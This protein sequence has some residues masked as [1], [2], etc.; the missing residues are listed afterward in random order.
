MIPMF[1]NVFLLGGNRLHC[2]QHSAS[3]GVDSKAQSQE[4][5]V[6]ESC[7]FHAVASSLSLDEFVVYIG[8]GGGD[9]RVV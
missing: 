4:D 1:A 8:G 3:S 6:E 2:F 5:V 9:G 7:V